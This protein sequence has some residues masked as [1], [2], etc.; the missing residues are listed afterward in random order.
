[1]VMNGGREKAEL[2]S[3]V[4]GLKKISGFAVCL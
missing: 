2:L 3:L 4:H 1:M